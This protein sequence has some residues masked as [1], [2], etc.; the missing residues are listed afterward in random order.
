MPVGDLGV[1]E[2][3]TGGAVQGDEVGVIGFEENAV[4][5][6]GY[7]AVG[8]AGRI[9]GH[10]SGAGTLV[11]PDLAAGAGIQRVALVGAGDI[12]DAGHHDGSHLEPPGVGKCEHPLGNKVRDIRLGDLG[13]TQMDL[14]ISM[15]MHGMHSRGS[16][17]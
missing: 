9:A 17:R 2:Q 7:P 14:E 16:F 3:L 6:Q 11:V 15:C 8:A 12:H 1:P 10:P 13:T 5:G 4:A